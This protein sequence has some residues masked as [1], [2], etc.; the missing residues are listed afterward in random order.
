MQ[1]IIFLLTVAI[2]IAFT[3][4]GN[5]KEVED[6]TDE[7][8]AAYF[9]CPEHYG[10]KEERESALEK[11]LQRARKQ[12]PDSTVNDVL[13]YRVMLLETHRCQETLKNIEQG[14]R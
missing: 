5:A 2:T 3:S 12:H 11:F 13:R 8:Y 14:R 1:K 10:T 6:M 7:E 4:H 9:K